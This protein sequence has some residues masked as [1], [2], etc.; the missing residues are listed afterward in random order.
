MSVSYNKLW[1]MLIDKRMKKKQ[2]AETANISIST[3]AKMVREEYVSL[4]VL[5]RICNALD[6][7]IEEIVEFV[8]NKKRS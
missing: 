1:K 2:L 7:D 5:E 4:E 3:L 6:C 8:E